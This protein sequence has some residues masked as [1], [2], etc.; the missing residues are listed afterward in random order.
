VKQIIVTGD[1]FGLAVPVNEAIEE[2]HASGILTAASL[3]VSGS[4]VEDAVARARR[5]PSLHV[6]LH[7][8][9]VEGR[10][11]L[12]PDVVPDLVDRHGE[13]ETRLF[14]AG[15]NFFFRKRVRAQLEAEIRAQFQAFSRTGLPLDH[16]NAHNHMHLHPSLVTL[17]LRVGSEFGLKALRIPYE[18]FWAS[19]RAARKGLM[20]RLLTTAFLAPWLALLKAK[21]GHARLKSNSFAFGMH[22]S[23]AMTKELLCRI[24]SVLPEGV[25]EIHLHPATRR[26]PEIDRHMR[27][28]AHEAELQALL[29]PKV[30]DA[31]KAAGAQRIAFSD[32]G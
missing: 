19:W 32:L 4:A 15:V 17:I 10:P 27:E 8:V 30:F 26:C 25:T 28:Y 22:D 13:F 6:G 29:S 23:G 21:V 18:P 24:L 14:R 9:L 1:D 31:L 7:L 20:R 3:M 12:S 5:L 11:V 16:V 2:A